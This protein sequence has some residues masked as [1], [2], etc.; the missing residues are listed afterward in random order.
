[1]EVLIVLIESLYYMQVVAMHIVQFCKTQIM[2]Y[3]HFYDYY[4]AANFNNFL[5][6]M[7]NKVYESSCIFR[8]SL[9]NV[10]ENLRFMKSLCKESKIYET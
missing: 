8:K 3:F 1:M 4:G 5:Y 10:D 6:Y 2:R 9:W 7:M